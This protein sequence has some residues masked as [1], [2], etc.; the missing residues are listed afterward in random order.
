MNKI[1]TLFSRKKNILSVYFTAGFPKLE[2]TTIILNELEK[3]GADMV[4]IGIPFSDP[5]ADGPTIQYSNEAALRNGM[6]MKLLF[7]QLQ[8]ADRKI[9]A[10][11]MGYFNPVLQF[12]VENFCRKANE[13]GISGVIIPDLPMDEYRNE[14]RTIFE[15]Y[16]LRNIFLITP[17][18]SEKRIRMMDENSDGFIYMVSSSST[19]G[20]TGGID[21]SQERYF[22]R[23]RNMNLKNPLMI[24]FG[25]SG[26]QSFAKA[27]EYA[28]GAIIGSAFIRALKNKVSVTDFIRTIR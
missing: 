15:K 10:L 20:A 19:T 4:E 18:T 26:N 2:D 22:Q 3:A 5:L 11:L 17:Q 1:K 8:S 6:S 25:I 13:T 16:D 24:G 9:P 14:Y 7:S 28:S 21:R 23:I 27:C 12:G